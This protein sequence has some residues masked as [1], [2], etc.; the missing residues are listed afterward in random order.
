MDGYGY[1][2]SGAVKKGDISLLPILLGRFH[3]PGP[4]IM[5]YQLMKSETQYRGE[6]R[7]PLSP[8]TSGT[9]V[10]VVT[11]PNLL[12]RSWGFRPTNTSP[13]R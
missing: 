8:D 9:L 6:L 10:R 11:K 13:V 12:Y 7:R 3:P 4:I 5:V 2:Q 1:C